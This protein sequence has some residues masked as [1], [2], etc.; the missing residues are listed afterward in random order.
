MQTH[1]YRE[2]IFSCFIHLLIHLKN[3]F[4][5]FSKRYVHPEPVNMTL[6]GKKIFADVVK[7]LEM[8]PSW[9][10]QVS[11][12]SNDK[13]PYWSKGEADLTQKERRHREEEI[14][15]PGRRD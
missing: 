9:I 15:W 6:F 7:G 11:P 12:K 5:G 1:V 4:S 3:I 13:C 8:R 10:T 2:F 14:K